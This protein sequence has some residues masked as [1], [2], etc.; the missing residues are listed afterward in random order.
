MKYLCVLD[1]EGSSVCRPY[2]VGYIVMDRRGNIYLERSI[3]LHPCIIENLE[4]RA[5]IGCEKMAMKNIREIESN[6]TKYEHCY[7]V[8]EFLKI[9]LE[10]MEYFN[11]KDIWAYN[12]AFDKSAMNRLFFWLK[13]DFVDSFCWKDIAPAIF[14]T[15]LLTKKY[16]RFCQKYE[17]YTKN[18]NYSSTAENV[19]RYLFNKPDFQEEHTGLADVMIE[20]DILLKV[21]NSK[22]KIQTKGICIWKALAKFCESEGI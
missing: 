7:N 3:A 8:E 20:K 11:V 18:G 1:V 12:V 17:L 19:Y 9:F 16:I 15:H 14:H 10:D 6:E 5:L 21:F 22:K 4:A 2:N 13:P